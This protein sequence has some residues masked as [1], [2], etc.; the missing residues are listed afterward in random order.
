MITFSVNL[1]QSL[2]DLSRRLEHG[3]SPDAVDYGT[4]ILV[5]CSL[6]AFQTSEH[7]A[8]AHQQLEN[9]I[10]SLHTC[11]FQRYVSTRCLLRFP[12]KYCTCSN[13]CQGLKWTLNQRVIRNCFLFFQI[14]TISVILEHSQSSRKKSTYYMYQWQAICWSQSQKIRDGKIEQHTLCWNVKAL[15]CH[16]FCELRFAVYFN[17]TSRNHILISLLHGCVF[18]VVTDPYS[19]SIL[20]IQITILSLTSPAA[21]EALETTLI[22]LLVIHFFVK[23]VK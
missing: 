17:C 14:G 5:T 1:R 18:G 12:M 23:T 22:R 16:G 20:F 6:A 9:I 13:L 7:S 2:L 15:R 3:T 8:P 11:L 4:F 21:S 10:E 19:T